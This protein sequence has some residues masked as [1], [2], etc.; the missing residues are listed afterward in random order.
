MKV[1][2]VMVEQVITIDENMSVK[3]AADIMNQHEIGSIIAVKNGKVT[4]IVT[5]RDFLKRVVAVDKNA[6]KIMVKDVMST[7]LT[8]V[9][10]DT[11]LEEATR[12]MFQKKI[13]KLPVVNKDGLVGIVSLTDIARFQP[14]LIKI[15]QVFA[16]SQNP[17][18]S[19]KKILDY[20]IV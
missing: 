1:Q 16:A 11:E 17:P 8:V 3:Q 5:E 20:Y 4:G 7:P 12:L 18:K 6:N 2:D 13:K 9:S 19:M 14:A 10:P 15:L